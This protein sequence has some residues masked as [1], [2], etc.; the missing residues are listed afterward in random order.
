MKAKRSPSNAVYRVRR[1]VSGEKTTAALRRVKSA[2]PTD[3]L[4]LMAVVTAAVLVLCVCFELTRTLRSQNE[5]QSVFDAF[6]QVTGADSYEPMDL[7]YD[8][9]Y[10]DVTVLGVYRS[11]SG[12][13]VSAYCFRLGVRGEE[14]FELAVCLDAYS[15]VILGVAP[16]EGTR[17]A[18][19]GE[20][21][22]WL[23]SGYLDMYTNMNESYAYAAPVLDG[24][25][26]TTG[27]VKH[28]VLTCMQIA[29]AINGGERI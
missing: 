7:E 26:G 12:G 13:E 24:A 3:V 1:A 27:A 25:P 16:I 8:S 11:L 4:K 14:T 9:S 5:L 2:F 17:T 15:S 20:Y 22:L 10:D 18:G 29:A 19:S 23:Q 28:A 21:V 6:G